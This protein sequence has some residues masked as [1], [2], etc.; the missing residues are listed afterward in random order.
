MKFKNTFADRFCAEKQ[1]ASENFEAVL[2]HELLSPLSRPIARA[3]SILDRHTFSNEQVVLSS[4][5][6][7][8]DRASF[9]AQLIGIENDNQYECPAW[10]RLLGLRISSVRARKQASI[11]DDEAHV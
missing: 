1:I 10:K 11:F 9:Q 2:F 8:F 5:R 3:A 4:L 6:K 7:T